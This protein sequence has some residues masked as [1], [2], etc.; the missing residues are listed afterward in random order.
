MIMDYPEL[1]PNNIFFITNTSWLIFTIDRL[2]RSKIE[3]N[4]NMLSVEEPT[5]TTLVM[6]E[7]PC[8]GKRKFLISHNSNFGVNNYY[9]AND[10]I[11]ISNY[12]LNNFNFKYRHTQHR[13]T[14][15]KSWHTRMDMD[16]IQWRNVIHCISWNC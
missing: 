2:Q 13:N 12:L 15:Y 16:S 11:P 14:L 3:V 10:N 4:F 5:D 7:T 6:K 9:L 8:N 1:M